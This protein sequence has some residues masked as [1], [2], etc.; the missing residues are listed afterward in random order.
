MPRRPSFPILITAL[1]AVLLFFPA[2][3]LVRGES[4]L[5]EVESAF[6]NEDDGGRGWIIGNNLIHYSIGLQGGAI[7]V[8]GIEDVVTGVDWHQKN[9][10]DTYVTVN[11]QRVNI[12]SSTTA[13]QGASTTEWYG[14]ARLD[15]R[16]RM[17]TPQLEM[18]RTYV[19]Y[20]DSS[21]IETWTTFHPTGT[22]TVVSS[23]LTYYALTVG[24]GNL[25][26]IRGLDVSD[27][28]GGPFTFENGDLDDGQSFEIGASRRASEENLPWFAI[29][30]S[31]D[32]FAGTQFFGSILWS[33]Q[34][35]FKAQRHGDQ[36]ALQLGLPGFHTS[37]AGGAS[38]E[39]PHAIFG[40]TNQIVPA[41][42][43][44]M[45][46]FI[47]KG[48]RHG[49][50]FHALS[51]YNTWFT[52]GTFI[53]DGSMRAEM[54]LA[55]AM[56]IE[57][58]VLD[59]GWWLHINADDDTDF[60][61]NWGTWEV[62][63]ERFPDGL[64]ALTDY[65]HELGMKFGVWV[66]PE[67]V[68]MDTVGKPGLAKES[69]LAKEN[70]QY[71]AGDGSHGQI[72]L[73]DSQARAW[74][75]DKLTTFLDDVHPDYLKW[76]NNG[77]V[78]C[79]RTTHGHGTEDGNFQHMRGLRDVLS[80][81]RD[82]Y[83]DMDIENSASGGHRL[84]LDALAF[85]DVG[86]VDDRSSPSTRVRHNL[87]GLSN[88]LPAGYL[89]TFAMGGENEDLTGSDTS[90]LRLLMRSR[91]G[92]ILGGTWSGGGMGE[93]TILGI[94]N[95]VSLYKYIRPILTEGSVLTPTLVDGDAVIRDRQVT[96][97]PSTTW[98]GWDAIE[99]VLPRTG[100]AVILAFGSPEGPGNI[101]VKPVGLRSDDDYD[102]ESADF[103]MLG[104]MSGHDLMDRG[105]ELQSGSPTHSHV[106]I[107]HPYG[108]GARATIKRR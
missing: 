1:V 108:R 104:T 103:G 41:V 66:E 8:R 31:D 4:S 24:N 102:V 101:V 25:C 29:K 61:F 88:M 83:P 79:N 50:S 11:N 93:D 76:D 59:A 12:G 15:L 69:F 43:M 39:S 53:D 27:D 51:T 3:V 19:C 94:S 82:R 98:S 9:D 46:S 42:S 71:D 62:D 96:T 14:G 97:Y 70:G 99:H 95:Q 91:M 75:L 64:G 60:G 26:W 52:Y 45:R 22:G 34:W 58:F 33:G 90:D 74:M 63:T 65:A 13:F 56:G 30:N 20:P 7:V 106:L 40:T 105:I 85:T 17:T 36:I 68:H 16:Y 47:D 55:A 54:R 80:E 73:A 89:F 87:E 32:A 72:C 21:V 48:I 49:R 35:R 44:A 28:D 100:E 38:L 10:S 6:V 2:R 86:W 37:V 18:T 78:N 92:G 107:F 57:Q 81:L 84:S 5:L 67:R 77:W 23:D